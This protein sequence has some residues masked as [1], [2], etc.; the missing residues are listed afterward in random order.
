MNRL[1]YQLSYEAAVGLLIDAYLV[2]KAL[3]K[4]RAAPR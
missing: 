1:L 3:T 2:G 4:P